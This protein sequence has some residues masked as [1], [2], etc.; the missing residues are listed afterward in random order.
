MDYLFKNATVVTMD[1]DNPVLYNVNL[2]V[3][4][5]KI[6]KISDAS[7]EG[8]TAVSR[9]IDC[10]HKIIMP[11]LYNCHAHAAMVMFR[12]YGNDLNLEDWLFNY[13]F[14]AERNWTPELIK[15]ATSLAIAEQIGSGTIAFA[16]MYFHMDKVAEAADEA[17]VLA[18]VSNAVIAFDPDS[19]KYTESS[20]Y[21]Q[22]MNVIERWHKHGDGRIKADASIHAVYTSFPDTWKQ[23]IEVTH[24][25]KLG[26]HVHL[27]E[28]KIEHE[29]CLEK[30]GKTPAAMFAEHGVFDVPTLAA[31][32]VWLTEDDMSILAQK[33][34]SLAHNPLSN[35]KLASG[36]APVTQML[37]HG[38]N[39]CM[40]TDGVS[41]NNSHDM[42]EELKM[43]SL[44]QKYITNDPTVLPAYQTL[45]A[46]TVN[47][48]IA[49]G[50]SQES[51]KI[52]EGCDADLLL[53]DTNNPRHIVC[54][55]PVLALAYSASGRDVDLT[56]VRGKILY[57]NGEYLTI[58]TERAMYEVRK[59]KMTPAK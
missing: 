3:N 51:G 27:S 37:K 36:L 17:G 31:H 50:R 48:A 18:N 7:G 1:R 2:Y 43:A 28:T 39:V 15:S 11:G 45:E 5:R 14:P 56:M 57:E 6:A 42:F 49:L 24:E 29:G 19:Y 41:S 58:D 10:T 25:H 16:D 38:I 21:R 35:L 26:M 46:A 33:N 13:I 32:G 53:I 9:V 34:V 40:G 55:D 59:A 47:G 44:L 12:G 23:V 30:F 54:H 8:E 20:E 52:K 22:T 4:G